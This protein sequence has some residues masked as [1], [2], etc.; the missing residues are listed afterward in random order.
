MA[1]KKGPNLKK[2]APKQ[3]PPKGPTAPGSGGNKA[4]PP[5]PFDKEAF[6]ARLQTEV[7]SARNELRLELHV[8][9]RMLVENGAGVGDFDTWLKEYS[10]QYIHTQQIINANPIKVDKDYAPLLK[11]ISKEYKDK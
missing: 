2:P 5:P 9:Y 3:T 4:K 1:K 11:K 8:Q 7:A 10:D 6:K